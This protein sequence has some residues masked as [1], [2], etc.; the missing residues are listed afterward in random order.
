M[1]SRAE[2]DIALSKIGLSY[3]RT[4]VVDFTYPYG[5]ERITF[6][7]APPGVRS[8][9]M[10]IFFP[11]SKELWIAIFFTVTLVVFVF[12]FILHQKYKYQKIIWHIYGSL[13]SS[14]THMTSKKLHERIFHASWLF[15]SMIL[16]YSYTVL[17]LSFLTVPLKEQSISNKDR[18]LEVVSEGIYKCYTFPDPVLLKT[19]QRSRDVRLLSLTKYITKNN[20]FIHPSPDNVARILQQAKTAVVATETDLGVLFKHNIFMASDYFNLLIW[21]IAINKNFCC[22]GTIDAFI[23]RFTAG[24]IYD[25]ILNDYLLRS[26]LKNM[27]YLPD[28]NNFSPLKI[29]DICGSLTV[30]ISGYILSCISFLGELLISRIGKYGLQSNDK[31]RG[32]SIGNDRCLRKGKVLALRHQPDV[33]SAG[34]VIHDKTLFDDSQPKVK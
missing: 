8:K 23:H 26:Q 6:A 1:V 28:E 24:G 31:F 12:R 34:Q 20:W 29:Q 33:E 22:K 32:N 3:D 15:S 21:S 17:L 27:K 14:T 10:A 7:T 19:L 11:F 16:S 2:A 25:K 5:M 9:E 4:T 13:L 18:L 30:L